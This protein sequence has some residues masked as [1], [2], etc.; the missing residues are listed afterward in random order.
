MTYQE[1]SHCIRWRLGWLPVGKPQ[2]CPNQVF[3]ILTHSH[4]TERLHM[5]HRLCLTLSIM[6]PLSFLLNRLPT[7]QF[8][9]DYLLQET[10]SLG[11]RFLQRIKKLQWTFES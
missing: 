4:A 5:H 8:Q 3:S 7:S 2:P 1:R 6:N 11:E 10:S 9:H